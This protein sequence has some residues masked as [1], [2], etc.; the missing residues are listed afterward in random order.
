[1]EQL[2]SGT[3][4]LQFMAEEIAKRTRELEIFQHQL[5]YVKGSAVAV[6]VERGFSA[7]SIV[8]LNDPSNDVFLQGQEADEFIDEADELYER[9]GE[10]SLEDAYAVTAH[11]YLDLLV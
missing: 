9:L 4:S 10:V 1:M 3:Q 2:V 7:V 6:D 8:D 5:R 11:P